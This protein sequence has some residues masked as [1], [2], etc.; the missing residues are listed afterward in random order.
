MKYTGGGTGFDKAEKIQTGKLQVQ[1]KKSV[2]R[3]V[4]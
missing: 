4:F 1:R 2:L 3:C